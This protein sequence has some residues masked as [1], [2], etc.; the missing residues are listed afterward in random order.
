MWRQARQR[1]PRR[2][3]SLGCE[4]RSSRGPPAC[5]G[6][7]P[8]WPAAQHGPVGMGTAAAWGALPASWPLPWRRGPGVP[9]RAALT[10]QPASRCACCAAL[11]RYDG[12][13]AVA[14]GM[15]AVLT[16]SDSVVTSYRD[17]AMHLCR[18]G[19]VKEVIGELMGRVDGASLVRGPGR[20]WGG[21]DGRAGGW[22]GRSG[23]P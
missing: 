20:G 13:E 19:T 8:C 23:R 9:C 5:L 21:H 2:A 6:P 10:S 1:A 16:Q 3:Q 14:V 22:A 18:G 11:R 15:H 17:H 7:K 4:M 12:Q